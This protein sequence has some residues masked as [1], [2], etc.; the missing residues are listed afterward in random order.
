MTR[1]TVI[2]HAH[3]ALW[4]AVR[5]VP[6][7]AWDRP[8]PCT[9]W[10]TAQVLQHAAGDQLGY[11]ATITGGPLPAEDPFQPS[12]RLAGAPEVIAGEAMAAAEAAWATIAPDAED[13]PVPVPPG[14]LPARLGAGAC[15]LDAGVHAWDIAVA[16]GQPSPL[17]PDLARELH[18]VARQIVEPLRRYGAYAA[19]L[20]PV[21]GEDEVGAL[22]RY[23]G[24]DPGWRR[25]TPPVTSTHI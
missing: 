21:P 4:S 12:G 25:D 17:T 5:G 10:T 19:A 20:D 13:V 7:D 24:R 18:A 15:A 3:E 6:A 23:L 1:W 22:L 16:T 14:T 2:D 8:T 9:E 11:A